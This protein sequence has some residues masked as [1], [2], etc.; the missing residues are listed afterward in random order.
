M[1]RTPMIE[2]PFALVLSG[3][4]VTG[5]AWETAF[6]KGLRDAGV[7]LTSADLIIGTS[8]GSIVGTQIASGIDLDALCARQLEPAD[9]RL[10]P[11]PR[12]NFLQELAKLRPELAAL[13]AG[14]ATDEPGLPQVVRAAV[15]RHALEA[16]TPAVEACR[17]MIVRQLTVSDWPDRAL[18]VTAVDVENG[19]FVI[20]DRTSG[21][22]LANAVASSCCVPMV[23]P[24]ISIKGRRY[25][26][27][28]LRSPTNADLAVGYAS[29]VI[30]TPMNPE[31]PGNGSLAKELRV[32]EQNGATVVLLRA[33]AEAI[34]SFGPNALNPAFRVAAA[35]AGLRQAG[36][37]AN[38]LRA[39][40]ATMP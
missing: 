3:G 24:P 7:D 2:R 25:M 34:A 22:D 32:L 13:S 8:A 23:W 17:A 30:I 15:G 16:E 12:V 6:L 36:G 37:M 1:L 29:A 38:E 27:G 26:D 21:V 39:R 5:V 33:G 18:K 9:P 35:E 40:L 4:G 28:G 11:T 31:H 14:A 19:D 10:E 20:W